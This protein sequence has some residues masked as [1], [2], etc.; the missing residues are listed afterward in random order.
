MISN[1]K[2]L[3]KLKEKGSCD[4]NDNILKNKNAI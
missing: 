2:Y 4:F 3:K 1:K